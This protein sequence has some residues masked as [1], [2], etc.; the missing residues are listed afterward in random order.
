MKMLNWGNTPLSN[1]KTD[2]NS[3]RTPN[4]TQRAGSINRLLSWQATTSAIFRFKER[5][6]RSRIFGSV[7]MLL[8]GTLCL[9]A[10]SVSPTPP[11]SY[12]TAILDTETVQGRFEDTLSVYRGIPYATP[13]I[14][15]LRW[16]APQ[17]LAK[18]AGIRDASEFGSACM[19]ATNNKEPWAQVGPQSEDCLF[20]NIWHP[21]S[22]PSSLPVMVFIHGGSLR[23]GAGG[24]PLYDGTALAKRGAVIV[25]INYRLG[26]LGYFAHPA[27]T[28]ENSDGLLGNYGLMDQIEALR[29]VQHN[30]ETF[31]GDPEN[32]TI[33]GESA[34]AVSVQALMAS[35]EANGLFTK[36]I[37]QSGG[38]FTLTSPLAAAEI[39]GK[40][41]AVEKGL[42]DATAEQLRSLPAEQVATLDDQISGLMTDGRVLVGSP[43]L[44]YLSGKTANT[45]LMIGGNSYEA[46]LLAGGLKG[47]DIATVKFIVGEHYDTLLEGY[48]KLNGKGGTAKEQLFTQSIAIQPSRF[49]ANQQAAHGKPSYVYYFGQVAVSERDKVPGAV[50]GAELS[51]IFGTRMDAETWDEEDEHISKL[52]GD[53]WV[54][55]ARAGDPN[56]AGAPHW[57]PV[58]TSSSPLMDIDGKAVMREAT[59]L[60]EATLMASLQTIGKMLAQTK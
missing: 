24:V 12:P 30:I 48:G 25:T 35:P 15:P 46:N 29:W 40:A 50:H 56:S 7:G 49:L 34:G 55:F 27:I 39:T 47:L 13:P 8:A 4:L 23:A 19:Q 36:A 59:P 43:V 54:N 11:D 14:G 26:R 9:T 22:E 3:D 53:Y 45:S 5:I 58:T 33:F 16:R 57:G 51:Y 6:P 44:A 2:L 42:P 38:G 20:L 1:Q 60:E 18:S 41:W 52:M 21:K 28:Q 17:P 10:C 31:G 37:S 32:V